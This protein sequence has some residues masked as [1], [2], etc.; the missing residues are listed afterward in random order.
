M[1]NSLLLV[2]S[3]NFLPKIIG[4][5]HIIVVKMKFCLVMGTLA[6]SYSFI[7]GHLDILRISNLYYL[8]CLFRRFLKTFYDC[9][10]DVMS[11]ETF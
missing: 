11:I 7:G 9:K 1:E 3:I 2:F 5:R 4:R 10:G 6:V 8:E